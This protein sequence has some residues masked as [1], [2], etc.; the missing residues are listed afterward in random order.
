MAP[1][2]AHCMEGD[3]I[4]F[5]TSGSKFYSNIPVDSLERQ[6]HDALEFGNTHS[7]HNLYT[8]PSKVHYGEYV[9]NISEQDLYPSIITSVFFKDGFDI[10]YFTP[11]HFS[12]TFESCTNYFSSDNFSKISSKSLKNKNHF[13]EIDIL[14][15][16]K[17]SCS[18]D[19][20]L[21]CHD[22]T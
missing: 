2:Q 15:D 9:Y 18:S 3:L 17:M 13:N 8:N 10:E 1:E 20:F 22:S 11:P 7:N 21:K 5:Y 14:E 4:T 16:T 6:D 19:F 12:T